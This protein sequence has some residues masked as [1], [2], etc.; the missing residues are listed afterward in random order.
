M[1]QRLQSKSGKK[2][3]FEVGK[4]SGDPVR[5]MEMQLSTLSLIDKQGHS[6]KVKAWTIRTITGPTNSVILA[7]EQVEALRRKTNPV[8]GTIRQPPDV[9]IGGLQHYR[10]IENKNVK[11]L[12]SGA[13]MSNPLPPLKPNAVERGIDAD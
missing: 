7:T 11:R 2:V 5:P 13:Y 10:F 6:L 1:V 12:Q 4:F 9:P 8:I 3:H